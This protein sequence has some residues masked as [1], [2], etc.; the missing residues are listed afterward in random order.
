MRGGLPFFASSAGGV[1]MRRG[2]YVVINAAARV[3]DLGYLGL[4]DRLMLPLNAAIQSVAQVL[5]PVFSRCFRESRNE[6]YRSAANSLRPAVA[7]PVLVCLLGTLFSGK[8]IIF[9]FGI[10][11][12]GAVTAFNIYI[13]HFALYSVLC[14]YGLMLN[15]SCRERLLATLS[16][17]ALFYTLAILGVLGYF[18]GVVG[19]AAGYVSA[20]IVS[21][22]VV[23]HLMREI[24]APR[25]LLGLYS[26]TVL[27][28]L[29]SFGAVFFV[30]S[31]LLKIALVP[32][33]TAVY[34]FLLRLLSVITAEDLLLAREKIRRLL[35]T[36]SVA[37]QAPAASQPWTQR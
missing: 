2:S 8:A 12:R 13:W 21:L 14:L 25:R 32:L 35:Q 36:S 33:A 26:K 7:L 9:I 30:P 27:T 4:I 5:Y 31:L 23:S 19:V 18:R 17:I 1:A 37:Y 15:A 3:A 6:F 28:G 20:D 16:W 22:V 10:K 34:I 11:Y 29:A 24:L